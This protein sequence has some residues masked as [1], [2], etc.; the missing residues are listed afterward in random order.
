MM[1]ELMHQYKRLSSCERI[2]LL[3]EIRRL[4]A[5]ERLKRA[6][7]RF[8]VLL[9]AATVLVGPGITT[10][11]RNRELVIGRMMI[12]YQMRSEEFTYQIIGKLLHRA[13][14]SVYSLQVKMEDVLKYPYIYREENDYWKK[15][16]KLIR[17]YENKI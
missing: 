3:N 2:Q 8:K 4:L 6:K 12:I 11:C 7:A 9:K 14:S 5:D 13:H 10:P 1:E 16:Q 15:F 17:E